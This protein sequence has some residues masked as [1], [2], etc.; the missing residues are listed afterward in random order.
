MTK[1]SEEKHPRYGFLLVL[2]ALA[3]GGWLLARLTGYG[4]STKSEL[5]KLSYKLRQEIETLQI[6]Q[7]QAKLDLRRVRLE[8]KE[9][10]RRLKEL[11]DEGTKDSTSA[12]TDTAPTENG[13][14]ASVQ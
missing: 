14:V 9:V 5:D 6:L 12:M 8:Q 10:L 7:E 4:R 1:E 2:A 11:E 13:H 3:L